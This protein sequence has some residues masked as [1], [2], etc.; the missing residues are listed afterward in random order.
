MNNRIFVN[1]KWEQLS[2]E[3][4]IPHFGYYHR[5]RLPDGQINEEFHS[6]KI[7]GL[8]LDVKEKKEK[9]LNYFLAS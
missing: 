9:A 2:K 5:Y 7:S 3:G 8:I 4:Y 1:E 6:D